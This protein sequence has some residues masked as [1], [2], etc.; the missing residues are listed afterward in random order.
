ML[1]GRQRRR[2]LVLDLSKYATPFE[3]R[4]SWTLLEV[5]V[6]AGSLSYKNISKMYTSVLQLTKLNRGNNI[7]A[8]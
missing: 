6:M 3:E 5:E 4:I 7:V 2:G 8:L 1:G